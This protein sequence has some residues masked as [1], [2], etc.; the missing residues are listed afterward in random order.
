MADTLALS[1]EARNWM[2]EITC[3]KCEKFDRAKSPENNEIFR[4]HHNF[5][6]QILKNPSN[7]VASDSVFSF[8]EKNV[9]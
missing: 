2:R 1:R 5:S 7:T 8:S 9:A 4:F 6:K 3:E